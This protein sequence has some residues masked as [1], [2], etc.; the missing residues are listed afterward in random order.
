M[1]RFVAALAMLLGF[2]PLAPL[3]TDPELAGSWIAAIDTSK[4]PMDIGL[5]LKVA[6]GRLV[7]ELKT[8]HG[9]WPVMQVTE[10]EGVWTVSFKSPG[11]PGTLSGRIRDQRFTGDWKSP[12]AEGTFELSRR[13]A[14]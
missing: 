2:L 9:D 13:K 10:K 7:G 12:M 4:G 14:R 8:A 3:A 11:G 1:T 6:D 5:N